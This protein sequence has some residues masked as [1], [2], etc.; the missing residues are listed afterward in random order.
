LE[1]SKSNSCADIKLERSNSLGK[2]DLETM[3][4][5]IT[6]ENVLACQNFQSY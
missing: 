3:E 5:S 2:A 6:S 1:A 4:G